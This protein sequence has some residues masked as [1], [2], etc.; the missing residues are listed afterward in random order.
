MPV[1]DNLDTYFDVERAFRTA[2]VNPSGALQNIPGDDD[3]EIKR[4]AIRWR[5]RAYRFR[6]LLRKRNRAAYAGTAKA[7][8]ADK[9]PY[10]DLVI[11]LTP[12]GVV[13]TQE[14][15]NVLEPIG[16]DGI[17]ADGVGQPDNDVLGESYVPDFG[18]AL[19]LAADLGLDLGEK[20]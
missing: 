14:A 4:K 20:K 12:T 3:G 18:A 7:A 2:L 19:Q 13:I 17:E 11:R 16:L 5:A 10:D 15:L 1:S 6:E 9:T 8:E